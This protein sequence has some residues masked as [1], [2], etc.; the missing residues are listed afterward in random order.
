MLQPQLVVVALLELMELT[1]FLV[2]LLQQVVVMVVPRTVLLALLVDLVV[3][4][5]DVPLMGAPLLV[6][7]ET[8]HL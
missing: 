5:V 2:P 4:L 7:Q 8:P 6:V 3:V 1:L